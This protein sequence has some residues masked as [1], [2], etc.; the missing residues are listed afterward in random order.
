MKKFFILCLMV[1]AICVNTN[2]HPKFENGIYKQKEISTNIFNDLK[3]DENGFVKNDYNLGYSIGICG[4]PKHGLVGVCCSGEVYNISVEIAVAGETKGENRYGNGGIS[5]DFRMLSFMFG[6]VSYMRCFYNMI[7]IFNPKVGF[8]SE[9][10]L[11][12][13][14]YYGSDVAKSVNIFE[15]GLDVGVWV[16]SFVVKIGVTNMK[17][18][19]QVGFSLL[20]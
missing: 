4:Y 7:F 20:F 10:Q 17:I 18:N 5:D 14:S 11:Y 16:K 19:A 3:F 2:A 6:Y 12:N 13:D 8:C 9:N 15:V 1:I